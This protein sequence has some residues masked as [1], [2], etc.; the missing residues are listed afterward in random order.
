MFPH[1]LRVFKWM[2]F[3]CI[4]IKETDPQKSAKIKIKKFINYKQFN[5]AI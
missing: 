2:G 3:S 4:T 5:V 1:N